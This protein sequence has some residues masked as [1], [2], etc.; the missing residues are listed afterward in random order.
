M[1]KQQ[2][3]EYPKEG[4]VLKNKQKNRQK[5]IPMRPNNQKDTK[6][7]KR[8]MT[9]KKKNVHKYTKKR[10]AWIQRDKKKT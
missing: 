8:D 10:H 5:N 3:R 7:L 9:K 1:W 6:W 2:Q 4:K